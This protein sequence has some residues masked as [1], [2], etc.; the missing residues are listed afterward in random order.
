MSQVPSSV[1]AM[2]EFASRTDPGEYEQRE[3]FLKQVE[4]PEAE[5]IQDLLDELSKAAET[6]PELVTDPGYITAAAMALRGLELLYLSERNPDG[7]FKYNNRQIF[8]LMAS[9]V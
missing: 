3:D 4:I 1:A 8:L 9:E 6:T 5:D 2:L 7:S